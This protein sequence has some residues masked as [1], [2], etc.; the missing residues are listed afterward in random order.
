[1]LMCMHMLNK[2]VHILFDKDLWKKLNKLAKVQKISAGEFIRRAV[3]E[4][5]E[6]GK[7]LISQKQRIPF[8]RFFKPNG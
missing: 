1:M 8:K 3:R 6:Q 2:R 4:E 5:L 7:E